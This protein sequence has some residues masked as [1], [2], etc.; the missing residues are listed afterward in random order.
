MGAGARIEVDEEKWD[1]KA[2]AGENAEP[3]VELG[4]V[5]ALGPGSD[6][7]LGEVDIG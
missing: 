2:E 6:V 5:G 4:V 3:A 1:K 7:K